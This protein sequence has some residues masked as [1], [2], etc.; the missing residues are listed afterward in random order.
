MSPL[1]ELY[2]MLEKNTSVR[3]QILKNI[4]VGRMGVAST[5]EGKMRIWAHIK[6]IL[7]QRYQRLG[8]HLWASAS[9]NDRKAA[10][11]IATRMITKDMDKLKRV[12]FREAPINI[13]ND[14]HQY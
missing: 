14:N 1:L 7:K 5:H 10:S 4:L 13:L 9:E 11:K 12:F 6:G 3:N 2:T 8:D